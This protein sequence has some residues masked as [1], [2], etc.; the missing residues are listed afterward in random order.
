ML[1]LELGLHAA[2]A[3][4]KACSVSVRV[5]VACGN[6]CMEGLQYRTTKCMAGDR[7]HGYEVNL[8]VPSWF[9]QSLG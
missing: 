8:G 1:G 5:R 7:V 6:C 2:I 3:A 4:W 9:E